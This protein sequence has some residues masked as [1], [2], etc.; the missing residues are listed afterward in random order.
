MTEPWSR[1]RWETC[2]DSWLTSSPVDSSP[3]SAFL[4]TSLIPETLPP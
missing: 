3:K 1:T 2:S 4:F